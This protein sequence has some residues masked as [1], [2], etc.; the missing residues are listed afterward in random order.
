MDSAH[1]GSQRTTA[2]LDVMMVFNPR[3][4]ALCFGLRIRQII[5]QSQIQLEI[6][7]LFLRA[8]ISVAGAIIFLSGLGGTVHA[9]QKGVK[10]MDR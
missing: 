9:E 4:L 2:F 8:R 10:R 1:A 3:P 6:R 5:F 7:D